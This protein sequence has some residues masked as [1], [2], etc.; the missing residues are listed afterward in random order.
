MNSKLI[1]L[2]CISLLIGQIQYAT[3]YADSILTNGIPWFDTQGRIVNA[4]GA[5][6]VEDNGRY[7]LFGEY[8]SDT[9]NAFPGF[10]CYS[11]DDF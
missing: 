1:F 8:K 10:S 2:I 7:Y 4:H 3:L 6:I 11:S 5:C 9:S